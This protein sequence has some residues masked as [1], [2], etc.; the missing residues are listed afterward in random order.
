MELGQKAAKKSA[1]S[2]GEMER[3]ERSRSER[4]KGER[5]GKLKML[6]HAAFSVSVQ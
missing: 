6:R 3:G 2:A 4:V 1:A 5:D